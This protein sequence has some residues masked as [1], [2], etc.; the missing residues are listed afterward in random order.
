[1]DTICSVMS[2]NMMLM[3]MLMLMMIMMMMMCDKHTYSFMWLVLRRL[4]TPDDFSPAKQGRHVFD[5][6]FA[7]SYTMPLL[8]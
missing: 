7:F 2:V 5:F 3:M 1:M 8:K 4:S 6:L